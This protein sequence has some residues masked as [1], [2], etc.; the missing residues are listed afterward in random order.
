[1]MATALRDGRTPCVQ[2][3]QNVCPF[4]DKSES[5][6]AAHLTLEHM[7][8][9]LAHCAS[10]Y[11]SCSTYQKLLRDNA[12]NDPSLVKSASHARLLAAS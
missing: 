10:R 7:A 11:R 3:I 1:M 2:E 8:W 9:A 4:V 12:A 5:C 6:C